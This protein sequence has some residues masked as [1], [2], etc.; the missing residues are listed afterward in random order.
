[1]KYKKLGSLIAAIALTLVLASCASGGELA[2]ERRVMTEFGKKFHAAEVSVL[3]KYEISENEYYYFLRW[4]DADGKENEI[5]M[6]YDIACDSADAVPFSEMSEEITTNW[7][8]VKNA[9]P[10]KSFS[11]A[12]ITKIMKAD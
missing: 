4:T 5:L 2:A 7:N 1:M 11:E 8:E 6:I 10:D 12:E 3:D 9:R